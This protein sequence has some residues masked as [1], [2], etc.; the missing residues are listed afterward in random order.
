MF[1]QGVNPAFGPQVILYK[2]RPIGQW[3][4]RLPR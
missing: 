1:N 3:R 4:S 2:N